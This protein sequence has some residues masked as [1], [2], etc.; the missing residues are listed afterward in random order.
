MITWGKMMKIHHKNGYMLNKLLLMCTYELK[1]VYSSKRGR[2]VPIK[3]QKQNFISV[4]NIRCGNRNE[5]L[6]K[7]Q[8]S[9]PKYGFMFLQLTNK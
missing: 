4:A 9:F 8:T 7:F 2:R 5:F 1:R 6:L 3:R